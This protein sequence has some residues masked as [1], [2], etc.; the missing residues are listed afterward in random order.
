[1]ALVTFLK[2][3]GHTPQQVVAESDTV[4]W[5]FRMNDD[6]EDAMAAFNGGDA[7]VEPREYNKV[8]SSTKREFYDVKDS[9]DNGEPWNVKTPA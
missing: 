8:F 7:R 9:L 5:Y 3:E 1:M 2:L 4:F 6:L